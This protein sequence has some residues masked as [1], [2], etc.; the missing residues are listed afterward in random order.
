MIV[1]CGEALIDFLPRPAADGTPAFAAFPGGSPFNVAIAIA[2]LDTPAGFFGGLSS[3]L[4]GETLRRA[5]HDS[6]VDTTLAHISTRPTT[7]AFVSLVDGNARS[8]R[9]AVRLGVGRVYAPRAARSRD[10]ARR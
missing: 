9:G 3:D 2:R 8:G 4:F 7:L 5:L 1:S 10:L 6:G